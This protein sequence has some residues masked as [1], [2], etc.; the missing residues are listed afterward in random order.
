MLR[1]GR[2]EAAQVRLLLVPC[3]ELFYSSLVT[4]V[5][6]P[7]RVGVGTPVCADIVVVVAVVSVQRV[8]NAKGGVKKRRRL[9]DESVL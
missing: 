4:V 6:R 9:H 3:A 5:G 1:R 2:I 8:A 7:P